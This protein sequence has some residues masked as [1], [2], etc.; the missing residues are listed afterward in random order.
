MTEPDVRRL[1][2]F[3]LRTVLD[4]EPGLP[5]TPPGRRGW[6]AVTGA[7]RRVS[8]SRGLDVDGQT[9]LQLRDVLM[10]DGQAVPFR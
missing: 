6:P 8:L 7:I 2:A 1:G 10:D 4:T 5:G 3:G 9:L